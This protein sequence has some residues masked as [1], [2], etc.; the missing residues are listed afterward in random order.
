MKDLFNVVCNKLH[1]IKSL[2][3]KTAIEK[4]KKSRERRKENPEVVCPIIKSGQNVKLAPTA[5]IASTR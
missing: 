3:K 2:I 4:K 1:F 5:L